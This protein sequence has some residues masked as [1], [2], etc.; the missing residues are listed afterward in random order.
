MTRPSQQE[1]FAE[2]AELARL[3]AW[4]LDAVLDLEHRDRRMLLA[5]AGGVPLPVAGER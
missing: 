3:Y 2:A 1:L 4:P 5:A